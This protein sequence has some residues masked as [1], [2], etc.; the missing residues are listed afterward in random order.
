VTHAP[1]WPT[2]IE[3]I[4]L[5]EATPVVVRTSPDDGFAIRARPILDAFTA[6]TRGVIINSPC[7]PTGAVMAESELELLAREAV[8]RDVWLVIDLC[9]E[10]LIYGS[11]PHNLPGVLNR[12]ARDRT[13]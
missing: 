13:V 3:Q 2:L 1:C 6:K 12:V 8:R 4:K 7:N 9:Y 11:V 5:A 10:K